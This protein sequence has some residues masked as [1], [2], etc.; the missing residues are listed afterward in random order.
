MWETIFKCPILS[1]MHVI[2]VWWFSVDRNSSE[3]RKLNR[4]TLE[5]NRVH[6][7]PVQRLHIQSHIV[8]TKLFK[9]FYERKGKNARSIWIFFC[10]CICLV[11]MFA[12]TRDCATNLTYDRC[13]NR[14][15]SWLKWRRAWIKRNKVSFYAFNVGAVLYDFE[16]T[17][18][19]AVFR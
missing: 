4:T 15:R 13:I 16:L 9:R 8:C 3:W 17:S 7:E 1:C 12:L 2:N 5:K 11:R 14:I 18:L 10:R 19:C 6:V